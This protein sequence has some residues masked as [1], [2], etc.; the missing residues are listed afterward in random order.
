MKVEAETLARRK[1]RQELA[2]RFRCARDKVVDAQSRAPD[3][4]TVAGAG[5]KAL[6][7]SI[8][9]RLF[10]RSSIPPISGTATVPS[11]PTPANTLKA[12]RAGAIETTVVHQAF[13]QSDPWLALLPGKGEAVQGFFACKGRAIPTSACGTRRGWVCSNRPTSG[14]GYA[15]FILSTT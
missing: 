12:L 10:A 13:F 2:S 11:V 14:Q 4:I 6:S 9:R 3:A 1:R 15:E 5:A 8:S 7:T